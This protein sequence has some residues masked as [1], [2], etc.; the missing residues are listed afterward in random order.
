MEPRNRRTVLKLVGLGAG[1][2]ATG[3]AAGLEQDGP[4]TYAVVQGD[5]CIPVTP[6]EGSDPVEAFYDWAATPEK[7]WSSNGTTE[8][9]R[10]DTSIAFLYEGPEATSLVFVHGKLGFDGDGGSASFAIDGLPPEGEWVVEDDKYDGPDN[11]DNWTHTET[12]SYVDWTWDG[13]RADGGVFRGV[14]GGA[15]IRVVPRFNESA[16]LYERYYQG[17]VQRWEFVSGEFDDPRYVELAM[18]EPMIVGGID[19]TGD[20]GSS[21]GSGGGDDGKRGGGDGDDKQNKKHQQKQ[22]KH[23]RKREKHQRK[24]EKKKQKHEKRRRKHERKEQKKADKE[25]K[26]ERKKAEKHEKKQRKHEKKQRKHREKE[27]DD[28]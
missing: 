21:G 5:R 15:T 23:R 24:R 26:K 27:E 11:Y 6:I 13:G 3:V 4:G 14:T 10:G 8:L 17:D 16:T 20:D 7:R 1:G 2:A 12:A 22:K 28:D 25:R 19:C 18:D 9:Q